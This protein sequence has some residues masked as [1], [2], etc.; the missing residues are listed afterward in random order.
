MTKKIHTEAF[1][2]EGTEDTEE[3]D[4]DWEPEGDGDR[5]PFCNAFSLAFE[6]GCEHHVTTL[7]ECIDVTEECTSLIRL[8]DLLDTVTELIQTC[9]GNREFER[10]KKRFVAKD[11]FAKKLIRAAD[12][13]DQLIGL[14]TDHFGYSFGGGW[15][16]GGFLSGGGRNLYHSDWSSTTA[17][18]EKA[19]RIYEAFLLGAAEAAIVK[20]AHGDEALHG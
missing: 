3:L 2:E 14:M 11:P 16:T 20:R 9:G 7:G 10:F 13:E 4:F 5:C 6:G 17:I 19:E 8:R 15:S 12:R 1:D 18:E